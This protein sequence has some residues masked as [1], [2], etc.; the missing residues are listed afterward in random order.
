[1]IHQTVFVGWKSE[2]NKFSDTREYDVTKNKI[3]L[4][5]PIFTFTVLWFN[6]ELPFYPFKHPNTFVTFGCIF[7][8][9]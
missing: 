3:L 5:L 8:I 6:M 9:R 1:M 2:I 7:I 4:I